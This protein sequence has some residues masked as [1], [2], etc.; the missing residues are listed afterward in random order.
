MGKE[1]PDFPSITPHHL[2]TFPYCT[3]H[4]AVLATSPNGGISKQ[5]PSLRDLV[6]FIV[7]H[8]FLRL[9]F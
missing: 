7:A 9:L 5:I 6:L 3:T 4:G 2:S 8:R 1:W